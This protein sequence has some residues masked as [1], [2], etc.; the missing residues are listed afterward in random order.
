MTEKQ[1][2]I[3]KS[4]LEKCLCIKK[5]ELYLDEERWIISTPE[6]NQQL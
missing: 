1:T 6:T 5:D 3:A 4:L 2:N